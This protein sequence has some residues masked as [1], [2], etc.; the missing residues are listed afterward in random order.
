MTVPVPR[1]GGHL[2]ASYDARELLAFLTRDED[3]GFYLRVAGRSG[4]LYERAS[5][6]PLPGWRESAGLDLFGSGWTVTV[7]PTPGELAREVTLLP[8]VVMGCGLALAGLLG[9]AL[10]Q[11]RRAR[12]HHHRARVALERLRAR[13]AELA[14][15]NAELERFAYVAS[16][17][18]QEP[19]RQV[20][21]FVELLG[22]RY[23]GRL[24]ADAD[25]FIGYAVDGAH[26]LRRLIDDLLAYSRVGSRGG[27]LVPTDLSAPLE[28][29][30][31]DLALAIEDAAAVV[32]HDPLPRVAGDE[33]QLAQLFQNLVGNAIKFRR[34][35][36]TP[37]VHVGARRVADTWELTV[38]DNGIGIDPEYFERI[39]LV[40]QRLHGREEY[41]GTG[42]G[43]ALCRR[44]VDRHGGR[45][46]VTSE[47]GRG[48]TF[49]FTLP[50]A[51]EEGS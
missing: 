27:E 46:W 11:T 31:G 47:P 14:R 21:S 6:E 19:L 28:R 20:A 22:R 12:R 36:V 1:A 41:P 9:A 38:A 23:R 8:W 43:L 3:P 39:F 48:S 16:H 17:D 42:I 18:L 40:F 37:T 15:S 13:E 49:H 32:T 2:A 24:D 7:A 34:P 26:R 25:D 5:L 29:A 35:E 4:T 44:I 10:A 30:L 50:G 45:L 51:R 33:T